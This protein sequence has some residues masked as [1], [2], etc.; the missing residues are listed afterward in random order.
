[1]Y[2]LSRLL[3]IRLLVFQ[4]I[5]RRRK[6][7]KPGTSSGEHAVAEVGGFLSYVEWLMREATVDPST[8]APPQEQESDS[9]DKL[10]QQVKTFTREE[11]D[12][13]EVM[14]EI[15]RYQ[16]GDVTCPPSQTLNSIGHL[17]MRGIQPTTPNLYIVIGC[18]V[19]S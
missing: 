19:F 3:I 9:D 5:G 6:S 8:L 16:D 2:A 1:M 14:E 11:E 7:T 17:L 12:E 13:D 18:H 10:L 15:E 4:A